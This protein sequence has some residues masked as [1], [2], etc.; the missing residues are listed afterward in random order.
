MIYYLGYG[1]YCEIRR[2][3]LPLLHMHNNF[4]KCSNY[5]EDTMIVSRIKDNELNNTQIID[6]IIN[7]PIQNCFLSNVILHA[8]V[9]DINGKY[10]ALIGDSCVG[11]TFLTMKFVAK[12]NNIKF[13]TDDITIINKEG[14]VIP[15]CCRPI[16]I[17]SKSGIEYIRSTDIFNDADISHCCKKLDGIIYLYTGS[18]NRSKVELLIKSTWNVTAENLMILMKI[19]FFTLHITV[20]DLQD[21]N[22]TLKNK[23]IGLGVL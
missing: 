5:F 17:R 7:L 12:I 21:I 3:G 6:R 10:I 16:L 11:K 4:C 14:M 22:Y 1:G 15:C 2:E 8:N 18:E 9:L 23:L 13:V 19:P 20:E